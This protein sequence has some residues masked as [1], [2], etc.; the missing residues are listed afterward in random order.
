MKLTV[1]G[2][3]TASLVRGRA[4][5]GYHVA[6]SS[7]EVL[8]DCGAGVLLRMM[9]AGVDPFELDL[10][11]LSHTRHPDHV[12]DLPMLLF[13]LN[14]TIGRTRSKPLVIGGPPGT[15]DF[16]RQLG[17]MFPGTQPRTYSLDIRDW[18]VAT[19]RSSGLDLT[20]RLV[21]HGT[22]PA[23]GFRLEDN[24]GIMAYSGDT[25]PCPGLDQ[26]LAGTSLALLDCSVPAG[27]EILTN[28]LNARQVGEV[29]AR[30]G[31]DRV[32]LTHRYP[33]GT[34]LEIVGQIRERFRGEVIPARDLDVFDI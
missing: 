1:L 18:T 31:V 24:S 7:C 26:L 3:G 12:S 15:A 30:A 4:C 27:L 21:E 33:V 10:I 28:H 22:T 23:L 9:E 11:A 16:I 8:L 34:A 6:G 20:T 13:A 14:Y 25:A 2:S 32:V 19:W 17:D 5:A 29:A